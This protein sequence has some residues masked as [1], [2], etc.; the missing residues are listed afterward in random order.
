MPMRQEC[1]YFESRT[2]PNG[3]TVRKCDLDLAPDAPWRCPEQCA[4]YERRLADV[5]WT[6]GTLITPATP[7]E[8]PGVDD[9]S[10]AAVL[11]EAENHLNEVGRRVIAEVEADR[12][13]RQRRS[14][15]FRWFRR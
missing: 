7:Q 4:S 5:A 1:K 9:G 6:H 10:A 12:A 8:P 3:E 13:A 15:R 11:D 14:R 2:Y